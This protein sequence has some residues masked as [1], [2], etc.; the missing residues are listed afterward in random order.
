[1]VISCTK[2]IDLLESTC[3]KRIF[4]KSSLDIIVNSTELNSTDSSEV[5]HVILNMG[6]PFEFEVS[7][8]APIVHFSK[9][10]GPRFNIKMSS[11]QYRKSH[12]GDETVV[13]SSYLH[14]GVSYTGKMSYLYWIGALMTLHKTMSIIIVA[15]FGPMPTNFWFI[16]AKSYREVDIMNWDILVIG[17]KSARSFSL[18]PSQHC[19]FPCKALAGLSFLGRIRHSKLEMLLIC[20]GHWTVTSAPT[21]VIFHNSKDKYTDHITD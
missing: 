18:C 4:F 11:Y 8:S 21:R 7:N 3:S 5:S 1:M 13:R 12:C 20:F 15:K 19:L 6:H 14:S 2:Y 10:S 16:M 9:H 17:P